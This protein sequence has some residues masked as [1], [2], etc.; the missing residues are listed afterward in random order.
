MRFCLMVTGPAYGTQQA[1]SAWL[2]AN[3]L[4]EEGH[5]LDSIFF[6]REGVLNASLLNA[7]ASDEF[8][9]TRG[10]QQLHEQQ[11]VQLNIC[12]AAALRRGI[13]DR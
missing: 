10:W 3:A 2:F 1:S 4:L 13:T 11:G 12:V 7:P 6:Y 8:D 5:T 9:L